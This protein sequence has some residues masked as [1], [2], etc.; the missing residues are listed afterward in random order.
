MTIIW[1]YLKQW[2]KTKI[3]GIEIRR[4][5]FRKNKKIQRRNRR[6]V[7]LRRF[8]TLADAADY[9]DFIGASYYVARLSS[10]T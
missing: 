9:I 2:Q 10:K 8:L 1:V 7:K 6:T 3:K 4:E 5:P